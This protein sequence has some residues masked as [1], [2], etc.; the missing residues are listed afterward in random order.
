MLPKKRS[1]KKKIHSVVM[2]LTLLLLGVLTV[3]G[4]SAEVSAISHAEEKKLPD[5]SVENNSLVGAYDSADMAVVENLDTDGK[6]ITLMTLQTGQTY[7]LFYSG[8]SYILD[9]YGSSMTAGQLQQ[10][11]IV[12]V[13]FLKSNRQIHQLQVAENAWKYDEVTKYDLTGDNGTASIGSDKYSLNDHT[14]VYSNGHKAELMDIIRGDVLTISGVGH[15][16]FSIQIDKGHG[17]VRLKNDAG[18]QGGWIEIGNEIISKV[19]SENMLLA[20]PEGTYNLRLRTDS[21]T[22]NQEIT[23]ERNQELILDCGKIKPKEDSDGYVNFL[24]QPE[25]ANLSIDGEPVESPEMVKLSYGIHEIQVEAD[26]YQ[27]LLKHISVGTKL[28]EIVVNLEESNEDEPEEASET[29]ETDA[30]SDG[31]KNNFESEEVPLPENALTEETEQ[32]TE[33]TETE[34]EPI[35]V[36]TSNK[37]Y[38]DQPEGVEVYLDGDYVGLAPTS[39]RKTTGQHTLTLRKVGYITKSYTILLHDDGDD[40]TYSFSSLEPEDEEE[41][42][43]ETQPPKEIV[44]EPEPDGDDQATDVPAEDGD[45]SEEEGTLGD[46]DKSDGEGTTGDTDKP[47]SGGSSEG[48]DKPGNEV[49]SGNANKSDDEGTTSS[50]NESDH[51]GASSDSN[52]S[53]GEGMSE[54]ADKPENGGTSG[55]TNNP[56]VGDQP[57]DTNATGEGDSAGEN[58]NVKSGKE[59]GSESVTDS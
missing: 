49:T 19:S 43:E 8:T 36:M 20:V 18:L 25:S 12:N 23:V 46:T 22:I 5:L 41:E 1:N 6:Q 56:D 55:D 45:K 35:H 48:T 15:E 13:T 54:D 2:L 30:D 26:G 42:P 58:A 44:I 40:I 17:Y 57:G 32:K 37:V 16:I 50:K 33:K 11:Q 24:L 4:C 52:K 47:G 7:N 14:Q 39:F 3:T 51:E 59:T 9:K 31:T 53:D 34:E 38:V 21:Q 28:A 27:T 10:G 29:E